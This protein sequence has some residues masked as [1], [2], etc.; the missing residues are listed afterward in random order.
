MNRLPKDT[1]SYLIAAV[2]L[3]LMLLVAFQLGGLIGDQRERAD[4]AEERTERLVSLLI[5]GRGEWGPALDESVGLL[6]QLC[7]AEPDCDPGG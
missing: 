3:T 2:T 7:D 6:R 1:P 4:R 5:E